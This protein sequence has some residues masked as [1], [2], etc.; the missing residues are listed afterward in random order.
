MTAGGY[1]RDLVTDAAG[2]TGGGGPDGQAASRR[3]GDEVVWTVVVGGGGGLR[4]GSPKQFAELGSARVIDAAVAVARRCSDGVVVVVPPADAARECAVAGGATRTESVRNGLAA[5]PAEATIVCVHDAA[6]PLASP[7]LFAA[8]VGAVRDGADGAVPAVAVTDTIKVIDA[9]RRVVDTPSRA[10][11]V[12]VQTPQAFRADV[13]RRA[14]AAGAEGTDDAALVEGLGA[15]VVVVPGEAA[16]DKITE[17]ADLER[18]R[19]SV[20]GTG[21]PSPMDVR[22]GHGF[23]VHR[24][25]DDPDRPLVLGGCRFD[26]LPGL[27]G[28]SDGDA[29]AHAVADALLGAAG[30][31]DIGSHFPDTDPAFAGADS[32]E[33]LRRVGDDVRAAGW[34]VGNADCSIVCDA[35]RLAP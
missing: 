26:G 31:G 32:V 14:H 18:A 21:S 27:A 6:R 12:A 35:P 22:V 24:V 4:F 28:H 25:G 16:N 30:L 13:L 29:V 5:V 9:R 33:L 2:A 1:Y 17:P 11:V 20:S 3:Y 23:D 19:R 7:E 15:T 10:S 8:V 34:S